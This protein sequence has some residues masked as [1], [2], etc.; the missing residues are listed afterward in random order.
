MITVTGQLKRWSSPEGSSHFMS[1]PDA[2]HEIRAHSLLVRRGF[3]S[4]KVEATIQDFTWRTSV[5]PSKSSGGYFLPVKIEV[6]RNTG[7]AAGD[8]VTVELELL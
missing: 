5:F 2:V 7:I 3:G 6:L 4:V 1:V 8:E